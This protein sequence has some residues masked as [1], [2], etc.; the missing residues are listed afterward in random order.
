M[1]ETACYGPVELWQHRPRRWTH[2]ARDITLTVM[3]EGPIN[4]YRA[5]V[6]AGE[7]RADPAQELAVEKLQALHRKLAHY[8]PRGAKGGANGGAKGWRRRI[9]LDKP[10]APLGGLYFFGGV[11]RGKT[12]LMDLFYRDAPAEKKRRTHFHAFMLDVH[13]RI[14]LWRNEGLA[15][16]MRIAA[17]PIPPLAE[18]IAETSWLLC[19]DEFEVLDVADAMILSRLFTALFDAGVVV[20]AT[21]NRPPD[22]L[23]LDGLNRARFL[24]FIELLKERLDVLQLDGGTDYRLMAFKGMEVYFDPLDAASETAL[25]AAFAKLHGEADALPETLTVNGRALE[26]PLANQGIARFSFAGLCEQPLGAADYLAIADRFHTVILAGVPIMTPEQRNEA[27]RFATLI[28]ILYDHNVKLV[29]SAAA[30][31][32]GLY[33]HGT[34]T[35]EFRRTASRLIEMQ[36]DAYLSHAHAR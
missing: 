20:V 6:A 3:S 24:P 27:K 9:G 29:C 30:P 19:F 16:E 25:D 32:D 23:Y 11:G 18:A 35:F 8:R 28:D 21:S 14:H 2:G 15:H 1:L 5:R 10:A 34:G 4:A 22:D 17:D 31:P 33:Q 26:V 12:M 7:L 13:K 36:S